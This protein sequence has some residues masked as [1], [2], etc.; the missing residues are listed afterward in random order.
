MVSLHFFSGRF[1][2]PSLN[3]RKLCWG[4]VSVRTD[5][6][7]CSSKELAVHILLLALLS[8]TADDA[9]PSPK[10][11]IDLAKQQRRD[12]VAK[13]EKELREITKSRPTPGKQKEHT[14][15]IRL[16]R[17]VLDMVKSGQIP[18]PLHLNPV[19][20][21][22]GQIG[23]IEAPGI[24]EDSSN[25]A[26]TVRFEEPASKNNGRDAYS[27]SH[28]VTIHGLNVER[29]PV[30]SKFSTSLCFFVAGKSDEAESG[31]FRLKVY[32]YLEEALRL[33]DEEWKERNK[34]K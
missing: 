32:P 6:D 16:K 12:Y 14:T 23:R 28:L 10:D 26:V 33:W 17:A 27:T 19:K 31:R 29:F 7:V 30:G 5:V 21:E 24:I 13:L 11:Y 3:N 20:L 8:T 9:V 2:L 25:K 18:P 4:C 34:K 22:V 15:K 1:N